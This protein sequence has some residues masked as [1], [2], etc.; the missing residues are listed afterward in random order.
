[1]RRGSTVNGFFFWLLLFSLLAN[2][3]MLGRGFT[4]S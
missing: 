1:M 2:A 3:Y 4:C